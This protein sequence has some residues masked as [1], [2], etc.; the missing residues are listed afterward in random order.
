MPYLFEAG[1]R[2]AR[3]QLGA[4]TALLR[5]TCPPGARPLAA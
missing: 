4:I 3:A 1:R 2:A 5:Q